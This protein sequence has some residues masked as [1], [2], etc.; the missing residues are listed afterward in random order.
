MYVLLADKVDT[1]L[2]SLINVPAPLIA[3]LS[4]KLL[5]ELKIR[6][7]PL[8]TALD[9]RLPEPPTSRVALTYFL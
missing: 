2:P 9:V 5:A 4:V 3:E 8:V 7:P 1:A 6:L